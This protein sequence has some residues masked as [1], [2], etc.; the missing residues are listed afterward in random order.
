M[1]SLH[2]DKFIKKFQLNWL[3]NFV[4][5]N[6]LILQKYNINPAYHRKIYILEVVIYDCATKGMIDN[7]P[8]SSLLEA[9][10]L[11]FTLGGALYTNVDFHKFISKD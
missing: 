3:C 1:S 8:N 6:H 10:Y 7:L 4:Q 5:T 11:C 9:Y 2:F